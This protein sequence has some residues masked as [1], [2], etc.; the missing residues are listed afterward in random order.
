MP[1]DLNPAGVE[2][3]A[4]AI[5]DLPMWLGNEWPGSTVALAT[6]AI[7]AYQSTI[8]E[9]S[10]TLVA[11]IEDRLGQLKVLRDTTKAIAP[12]ERKKYERKLA[13]DLGTAFDWI[14]DDIAALLD[15]I[16]SGGEGS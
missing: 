4:R 6:T 16:R 14:I 11:E 1:T 15:I 10:E 8:H 12:L 5:F 3:A 7:A 13:A 2:A 9:S